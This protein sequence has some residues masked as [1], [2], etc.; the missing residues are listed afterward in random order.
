ML[1]DNNLRIQK[2]D[3]EKANITSVPLNDEQGGY[4]ATLDVFHTLHC[5]NK[6]RKLHYSDYYNDPNPVEDQREHFDHCID[7]LRQVI[8]C[9]GDVSL[10]PYQWKDDY[11]WPWPSMR[12][13]HQCRNW[14]SLMAW[15]KEHYIPSLTGPILSHPSLGKSDNMQH[16]Y[17]S[18]RP[19]Q[20]L[21]RW[22]VHHFEAMNLIADTIVFFH[23]VLATG[24][25]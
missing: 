10:H 21:I 19:D 22:Q 13:E 23:F 5:V 2:E 20:M 1:Q 14:D 15:S 11:R 8:M 17:I 24:G 25:K 3:L 12:T 18:D 9:H 7:L 16:V 6:I 4:L